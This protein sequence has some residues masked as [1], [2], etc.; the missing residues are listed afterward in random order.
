M[1]ITSYIMHEQVCTYSKSPDKYYSMFNKKSQ[2]SLILGIL[3]LSL[4]EM[5]GSNHS[6]FGSYQPKILHQKQLL[7]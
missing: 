6:L 1:N 3:W 7:N 5:F 4:K 2:Y